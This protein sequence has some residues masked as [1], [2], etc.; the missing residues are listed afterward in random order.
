MSNDCQNQQ[1]STS[2]NDLD[3][4]SGS[5]GRETMKTFTLIFSQTSQS[6]MVQFYTFVHF[7][8]LKLLPIL[9]CTTI[10]QRRSP[11]IIGMGGR[12]LVSGLFFVKGGGGGEGLLVCFQIIILALFVFKYS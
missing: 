1:F 12:F 6:V 4:Q 7:D 8:L 10:I 2:F 5:H 11:H 9:F 3:L